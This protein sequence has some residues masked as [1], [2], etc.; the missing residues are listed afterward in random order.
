VSCTESSI[1]KLLW[2][3]GATEECKVRLGASVPSSIS[4]SPP[5]SSFIGEK[6]S[7]RGILKQQA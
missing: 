7:S 6:T 1:L 3:S 5:Q 4:S 2:A